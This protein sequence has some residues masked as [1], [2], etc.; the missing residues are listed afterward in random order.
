M[1]A[2]VTIIIK[3]EAKNLRGSQG[4]PGGAGEGLGGI[5]IMQRQYSSN[6]QK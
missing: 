6:S 3:E 5:E 2:Y 1:Y 4:G